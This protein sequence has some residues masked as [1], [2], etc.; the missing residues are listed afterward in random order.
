[1]VGFAPL[2]VKNGF[3]TF[4]AGVLSEGFPLLFL[5]GG[6]APQSFPARVQ[7]ALFYR[8]Y[9]ARCMSKKD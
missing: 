2:F 9:R 3:L 1:M 5:H 6:V 8:V 7:R 4:P